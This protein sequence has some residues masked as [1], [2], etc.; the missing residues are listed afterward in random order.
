[1]EWPLVQQ[2]SILEYGLEGFTKSSIKQIFPFNL[3][4][5]KMKS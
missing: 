2:Y 5:E 4:L 1:M 3:Y